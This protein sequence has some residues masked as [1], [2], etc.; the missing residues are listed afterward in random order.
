MNII[1][2]ILS[3]NSNVQTV[4]GSLAE[5]VL[6]PGTSERAIIDDI[7]RATRLQQTT[8]Y[9]LFTIYYL[10]FT[11]YLLFTKYGQSLAPTTAASIV[12]LSV[13]VLDCP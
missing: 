5:S 3:L 9:K 6:Q 7:A 13:K 1:S 12:S 10:L 4:S 8:L 11:N 2:W